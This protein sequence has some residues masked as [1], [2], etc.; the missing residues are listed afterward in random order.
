MSH[1]LGRTPGAEVTARPRRGALQGHTRRGRAA[2]RR[3]SYY[4]AFRIAATT[5]H[6]AF[7]NPRFTETAMDAI[8]RG[9]TMG[10]QWKNLHFV[11]WE[12]QLD[13]PLADIRAEYGVPPI[14]S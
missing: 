7:V 8:A 2:R 3:M 4:H 14:A 6:L 11:K 13:R 5:A 10:R 9:W 12:E 1:T